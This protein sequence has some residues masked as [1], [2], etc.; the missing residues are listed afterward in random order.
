MGL[1]ML[2][3][4]TLNTIGLLIVGIDYAFFF[5][6]LA[7]ILAII[8]YIGTFL[9]GLLPTLYAFMSYDSYWYPIGVIIVFWFVQTLEGNF[10]SPKI[11][12]GNLN[13]NA[14][15]ALISLIAGGFLWGIS[16]MILFLPFMA[17]F[18]VF[19]ENYEELHPIAELMSDQSGDKTSTFKVID[20]IKNKVA[21]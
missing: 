12:G 1:L 10:L 8:P 17:I 20:K 9:G 21:G 4:G 7:A 11:V 3:L 18:K 14:M 19:C 16:G 13:L 2:I 15:T 5:G 6:F